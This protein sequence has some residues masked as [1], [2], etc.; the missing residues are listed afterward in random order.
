MEPEAMGKPVTTVLG[1]WGG[2][3]AKVTLENRMRG[4]IFLGVRVEG[5]IP[6]HIG[7]EPEDLLKG[8]AEHLGVEIVV[9]KYETTRVLTEEKV[10]G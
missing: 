2:K 1:V 3:S 8:L 4:G 6:L 7:L 9:R 10:Y 5:E